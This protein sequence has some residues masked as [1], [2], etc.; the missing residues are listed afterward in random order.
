MLNVERIMRNK[1]KFQGTK[2]RVRASK[3]RLRHI[4]T[5][6]TVIVLIII[7]AVSSFIIYSHLNPSSKQNANSNQNNNVTFQLKAAIVDQLSLTVPNQTFI[8][9]ATNILTAAN[10]TVDYYEGHQVTVD[11][12]RDLPTHGY[13]LVIL[14]VHAALGIAEQP[15]VALFTA[16]PYSQSDYIYEQWN[17]HL[18]KV[19]YGIAGQ[20]ISFYFA[21]WPNFVKYSM[22][23]RFQNTTVIMMGCDGLRYTYMAE[24]FVENGAKVYISWNGAV[25]ASH[26]D[27]AT[28]HLLQH[29]I[30]ERQPIEQAV[31][32][33]MK[34]AGPDPVHN[35]TLLHYPPG[36]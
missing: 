17:D 8:Q 12:Y 34:E 13:S 15:P 24:A 19:A 3:E 28:I 9:T 14:R 23:G 29:L 35:S 27:Q 4:G 10:F 22:D 25:S 36:A 26:T 30:T 33:T 6:I 32:E 1:K 18:I 2:A 7:I 5:A 20:E 31:T 21:V 11:L 16:E